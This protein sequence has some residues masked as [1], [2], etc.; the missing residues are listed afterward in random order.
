[1]IKKLM[2]VAAVCVLSMA[3]P[4]LNTLIVLPY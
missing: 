3:Q 2:T 4:K 1:M